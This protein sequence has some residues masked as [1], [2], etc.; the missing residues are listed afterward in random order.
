MQTFLPYQSLNEQL[1][2]IETYIT[3]CSICKDA[4]TIIAGRPTICKNC[5]TNLAYI[6]RNIHQPDKKLSNLR[7]RFLAL[8]I[9]KANRKIKLSEALRQAIQIK[10]KER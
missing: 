7:L 9:V 10:N 1:S 2:P 5:K 6:A 3:R 4:I 8:T